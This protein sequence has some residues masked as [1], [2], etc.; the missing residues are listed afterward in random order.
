MKPK[1]FVP[2]NVRN[3]IINEDGNKKKDISKLEYKDHYST[4]TSYMPEKKIYNAFSKRRYDGIIKN[5]TNNF[6]ISYDNFKKGINDSIKDIKYTLDHPFT[7][8]NCGFIINP[9]RFSST[10]FDDTALKAYWKFNESS[11]NI[12]NESESA[13]DLGSAA[14]LIVTGATYDVTG[15]IDTA[16]SFDGTNDYALAGSSLSQWNYAHSTT[17]TSTIVVW[18]LSDVDQSEK[19]FFD[20]SIALQGAGTTVQ[21]GFTFETRTTREIG[22]TIRNTAGTTITQLITTGNIYPDNSNYFMASVT[23]DQN[24]GSDNL[25]IAVNDGTKQT[26][27]K[28]SNTPTNGNANGIGT[29]AARARLN[30]GFFNG[31]FDEWSMWSKVMSD[32][33]ITSLYNS[34]DGLEIY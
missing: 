25:K 1:L 6:G 29:L 5:V 13:V 10:S 3:K 9:Y 19:V 16:L 15:K 28:S 27:T 31:N 11:G 21:A 14:D 34:G 17:A 20:D 23:Y 18:I 22:Y 24:L 32:S 30:A 26:A 33:D 12:I 7:S 8:L 4:L 2:F